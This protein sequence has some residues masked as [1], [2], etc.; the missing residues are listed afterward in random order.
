MNLLGALTVI[1]TYGLIAVATAAFFTHSLD[2][3]APR[4]RPRDGDDLV[5][6]G[7]AIAWPMT[8]LA[9][10]I[11]ILVATLRAIRARHHSTHS[12]HPH[13]GAS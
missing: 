6:L 9:A 12:T 3:R 2:R 13:G 7:L 8:W 4:R 5:T 10:G 11:I 1:A